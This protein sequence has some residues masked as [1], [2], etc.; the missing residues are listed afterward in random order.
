MDFSFVDNSQRIRLLQVLVVFSLGSLAGL[1]SLSHLL[2]FVLKRY[3]KETYAV[4][5]GF[6]TGSLGVV[7]PWKE[8]V[9]KLTAEGN[10][11]LDIH[12]NKVL[13]NY[14]RYFPIFTTSETWIAVFF[15]I[16]G[17][18]IVLGLGWYENRNKAV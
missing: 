8:K 4:I 17:V 9:Y 14:D 18:F 10:F 16:I 7:W 6:I 11:R 3:K 15:I 13:D 2:G 12:G 1:V 5:I